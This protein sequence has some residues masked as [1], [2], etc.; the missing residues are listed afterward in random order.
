MLIALGE[1]VSAQ[2][3]V[4]LYVTF[5]IRDFPCVPSVP[6]HAGVDMACFHFFAI[7]MP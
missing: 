4:Y 6:D 2:M 5:E 3:H 7:S 1:T